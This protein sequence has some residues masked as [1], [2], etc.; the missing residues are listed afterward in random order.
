MSKRKVPNIVKEIRNYIPETLNHAYQKNVSFSQLSMFRQCPKKWSLQY[1]EGHKQYTP[2]IHTVFGTALHEAVQ[3][4][5]TVMY[6]ESAAAA[7]REDIIGMFED[8]LREEY[9]KQYKRSNSHFS[10][11]DQ[12][13]EFY[14]DGVT[15]INYLIK[16]RNKYFSKRGWYLAGCEV[17]IM[18]MPN[19]RYTN[20]L[21]QGFLDVVLYHE[22][23]KKFHI[24]DIKTSTSGWNARAKK[25]EDKQF[26]LILYKKFF[27]ETFNVP[28]DDIDIEFF[29]VKRRLY[30]SEDY[31]IP[32]IQ[33][34]KPASGKV[35]MN[36]ASKALEEFITK[37]FDREGYAEV[38]HTPTPDNPNNNCN[39]CAFHKTHL[40]PA[41]S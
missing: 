10:S 3:H 22:P 34:F 21:Y 1:K 4:Y 2:T 15:I 35:K 6:D 37:A 41:T 9:Q 24:I 30:K 11:P 14:D 23:T 26:Q 40:C 13:R 19:K 32:R 33:Q 20:V 17:P 31:V 39:W 28:L 18:I 8:C 7:D 16:N 12:L 5:L 25:D 36:R 27:S 38:E 29:I